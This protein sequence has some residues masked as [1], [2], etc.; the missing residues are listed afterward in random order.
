MKNNIYNSI[1]IK[2]RIDSIHDILFYNNLIKYI[3]MENSESNLFILLYVS[4]ISRAYKSGTYLYK[5]T[6]LQLQTIS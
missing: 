5:P 3:N 1:I 4:F 6:L 2:S